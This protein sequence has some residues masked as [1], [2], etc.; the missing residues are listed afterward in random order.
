[1]PIIHVLNIMNGQKKYS[2]CIFVVLFIVS[3]II[4]IS[5][6]II[7]YWDRPIWSNCKIV[8]QQKE[9]KIVSS[10]EFLG[11]AVDF[12]QS[13]VN[14][15]I[16]IV[17]ILLVV[18]FAYTYLISHKQARE[19]ID[20]EIYS[21]RFKEHLKSL[22]QELITNTFN[23][24]DVTELLDDLQEEINTLKDNVTDIQTSQSKY[25]NAT[26]AK[27]TLTSPQTNKERSNGNDSKR[28]NRNKSRKTRRRN[29]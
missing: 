25:S 26:S 29:Y 17:S 18:G 7:C 1:M 27:L 11:K 5:F 12:Y 4:N 2:L 21:E 10:D 23:N 3:I 8:V 6:I 9:E 16:A 24:Y 13:L 19:I 20:E 14:Y 15:Q 28:N 22:T